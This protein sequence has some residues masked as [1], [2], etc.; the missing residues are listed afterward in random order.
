MFRADG[1]LSFAVIVFQ[2]TDDEVGCVR[3][4]FLGRIKRSMKSNFIEHGLLKVFP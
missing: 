3:K 4:T 1:S 2:Q